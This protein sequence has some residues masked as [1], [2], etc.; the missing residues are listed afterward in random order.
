[1]KNAALKILLYTTIVTIVASLVRIF[2]YQNKYFIEVATIDPMMLFMDPYS[3]DS[4]AGTPST[5]LYYLVAI[6]FLRT[7][8]IGIKDNHGF[9]SVLYVP[10]VLIPIAI[11]AFLIF[12]AIAASAMGV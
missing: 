12:I 1:M 6:A 5:F 11:H 7:G 4:F 9:K 2:L 8:I 10:L 3:R